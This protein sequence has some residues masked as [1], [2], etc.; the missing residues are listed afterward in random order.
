MMEPADVRQ[1]VAAETA[2]ADHMFRQQRS[3]PR[4]CR[5]DTALT[6]QRRIMLKQMKVMFGLLVLL[7]AAVAGQAS[8]EYDGLTPPAAVGDPTGVLSGTIGGGEFTLHAF[9]VEAGRPEPT[10]TAHVDAGGS[11]GAGIRVGIR[12]QRGPG[13]GTGA[14]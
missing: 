1:P 7:A 9:L 2:A 3:L 8:P 13:A 6:R 4:S 5:R 11:I 14:R 12:A 10:T